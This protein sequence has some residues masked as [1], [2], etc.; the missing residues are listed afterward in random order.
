MLSLIKRQTSLTAVNQIHYGY[1]NTKIGL[2][3]DSSFVDLRQP[4]DQYTHYS[5]E[6]QEED[7]CLSLTS[8]YIDL[9]CLPFLIMSSLSRCFDKFVIKFIN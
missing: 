4:S 9:S 1:H 7:K 5:V 3:L 2:C 6:R 8:K